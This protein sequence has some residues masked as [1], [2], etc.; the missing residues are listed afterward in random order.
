MDW[1]GAGQHG[2]SARGPKRYSATLIQTSAVSA[3]RTW[4]ARIQTADFDP[5]RTLG[6]LVKSLLQDS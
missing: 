6:L 2:T 1:G 5:L 4:R 3:H